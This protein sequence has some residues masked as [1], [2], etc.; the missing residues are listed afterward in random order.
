MWIGVE[1]SRANRRE[2]TG[3]EW[4]ACHVM[5]ELALLPEAQRHQWTAY[6]ETPLQDDLRSW[7]PTWEERVLR[8]PPKYLW[9]Q[10]RLTWE[11]R[12]RPPQVLFVPAHVLPRATPKKTVVTVHDVGFRRFPHLYKP[13]QVA[14]HEITTRDIV[15]SNATILTV[16]EFS[17]REI[18]DLYHAS[19][20]QIQVTPLG[21]DT[22]RYCPQTEEAKQR[23]REV[24]KLDRP[25]MFFVG[26]LEEKK[27]IG[28]LVRAFC[29]AVD[30]SNRDELLVLAGATGKGW[31]EVTKWL[32][33]HP[34]RAQIRVLGYLSEADKPALTAAASWYVQ[35]SLYEGFGLPVLEAM[36]CE[37]PVLCANAGSLPEI[38]GSAKALFFN[39]LDTS[40]MA[41]TIDKALRFSAS[42]R[43]A[44][45]R[46]GSEHAKQF[47]WKKTAEATLPFLT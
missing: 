8:W 46:P 47:T 11:M 37:T 16:S 35:P 25:F 23:V 15:H 17:K 2:R 18:I 26:R 38:V 6:T 20:D 21:I 13:I 12:T 14:Y 43:E 10:L 31:E 39:P 28:R 36:A 19:P 27:N 4:Y 1:A 45:I 3:V 9:T 41:A 7:I 40:D 44:F 22:D 42:E 34:R 5:R 33:T 24:Y 32:A 30:M 29:E